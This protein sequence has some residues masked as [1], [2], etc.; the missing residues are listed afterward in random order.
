DSIVFA[1]GAA[2]SPL[3][4]QIV[5]DVLGMPARVP[6]V[7]EASALGAAILAGYGVRL[8]PD[9]PSAAE[10]M[11]R[12]DRVYEPNEEA[13]RVYDALYEPWRQV[14]AAQLALADEGLT[15]HMWRAP[16]L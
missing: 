14:Y 5:A 15:R 10:A 2:N 6:E 4:C 8:Y 12:W 9:I 13:K 3:W 11:V 1:N 16:G 7:M